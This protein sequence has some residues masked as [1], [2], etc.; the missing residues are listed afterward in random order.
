LFSKLSFFYPLL[1]ISMEATGTLAAN[2]A[3]IFSLSIDT[4]SSLV[5]SLFTGRPSNDLGDSVERL[6]FVGDALFSADAARLLVD[7]TVPVLGAQDIER[8][9]PGVGDLSITKA[10]IIAN[11]SMA[12]F[13][14]EFVGPGSALERIPRR[15][16][17]HVH[18]LG[19][20]F[21]ALYERLCFRDP[22]RAVSF[23]S[24][25]YAP[26]V[27]EHVQ[28]EEAE[29]DVQGP[30]DELATI[31]I[32]RQGELT[33]VEQRWA[34]DPS[35]GKETRV[36]VADLSATLNAVFKEAVTSLEETASRGLEEELGLAVCNIPMCRH[37]QQL[38]CVLFRCSAVLR[39]GACGRGEGPCGL[40]WRQCANCS[41][42]DRVF[43]DSDTVFDL[44]E[45][46]YVVPSEIGSIFHGGLE[47]VMDK[48]AAARRPYPD[49]LERIPLRCVECGIMAFSVVYCSIR[50]DCGLRG[51]SRRNPCRRTVGFSCL[52]CKSEDQT[53]LLQRAEQP[54]VA[55][56]RAQIG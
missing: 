18:V 43:A 53:F 13:L 34:G 35:R 21:E 12:A 48:A 23:L 30:D 32:R 2:L 51:C 22:G 19:T 20:L 14:L 1:F 31:T 39:C 50:Y 16:D 52:V 26:F 49:M 9:E 55:T 15:G 36:P 4:V 37:D 11:R 47:M 10:H 24:D 3:H 42:S 45:R 6:A 33:T 40:M 28:V 17:T 41:Y 38:K 46:R 44:T 7:G 5:T 29:S 54:K 8:G 56:S 27:L 25:V